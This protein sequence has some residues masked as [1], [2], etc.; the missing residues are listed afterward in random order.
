MRILL[1]LT[2]WLLAVTT[3]A[4]GPFFDVPRIT[5]TSVGQARLGMRFNELRRLYAGCTFTPTH[6]SAYGF[7]AISEKPDATLVSR[8]GRKLFVYFDTCDFSNGKEVHT[9]KIAGI[10]VLHSGYCTQKGIHTGSSSGELR[11]VLPTI[12]VALSPIPLF[13]LQEAG[14]AQSA[15]TYV[16]MGQKDLGPLS[17]KQHTEPVQLAREVGEREHGTEGSEQR[18]R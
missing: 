4:Q 10:I 11:R 3:V 17:K 12:K 7:D 16:F 1:L 14:T 9:K 5:E 8:D 18:R 15:I 2:Y 6:L 13:D